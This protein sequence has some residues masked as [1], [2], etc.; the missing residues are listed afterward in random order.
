MPAAP[1][2]TPPWDTTLFQ[3]S[4]SSV[5]VI[6]PS[7]WTTEWNEQEHT[8][9][10]DLKQ[11]ITPYETN[12]TWEKIKKISNPYELIY[13]T[14]SPQFPPSLAIQKPLS[15]SYFKMI[16]MLEVS[17]FFPMLSK[18]TQTLRSAHVAEGPGGFIE[19]FC[20]R[21]SLYKKAVGKC[22]AMTLKPN[23]TNIPGWRRAYTFLQK[24]PEVVIHYGRDGTGDIYNVEN[25]RSFLE[26]CSFRVNLFTA[27]GGFDFSD[28]YSTQE[29]NVYPLLIASAKIGLQ[30]LATDGTFIMKLFD[31]FGVPTQYLLRVITLCFREWVLYKPATSRPCNSE[32]YL[33]A[34]GFRRYTPEIL[35]ILSD[36]EVR[37]WNDRQYPDLS[38]QTLPLWSE[39]EEAYIRHHI[40]SFTK[41]QCETI[42]NSFQLEQQDVGKVNWAPYITRAH[43]W[44]SHFRVADALMGNRGAYKAYGYTSP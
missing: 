11:A 19:A 31:I 24:H 43:D 41:N 23:G 13:T 35:G 1:T 40:E 15:R 16:E 26:N 44:C 17:Q 21:C 37:Y 38:G 20:E 30:C 3:K 29:K 18:Q 33:I 34:R 5:S 9:L 7:G 39:K 22:L 27:D 32:R 2:G 12:H 36:M 42:E 25:Q 4:P 8:I 28:D 10:N 6:Q 14:E